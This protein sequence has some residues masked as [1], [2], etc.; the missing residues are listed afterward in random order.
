MKEPCYERMSP[1][2]LQRHFRDIVTTYI[3][4]LCEQFEIPFEYAEIDIDDYDVM[5]HFEAENWHLNLANIIFV[6]DHVIGREDFAEWWDYNY[7]RYEEK[8]PMCNL[9]S[10][11]TLN[12]RDIA[13][14][15]K[16][17]SEKKD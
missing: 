16:E 13:R 6:V 2:M 15:E 1:K 5:V 12:Y 3:Q 7:E 9:V 11:F 8:K 17:E 10:W 14:K 4:R